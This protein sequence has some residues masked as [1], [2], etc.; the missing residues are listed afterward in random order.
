MK[1]AQKRVFTYYVL[2]EYVCTLD[3][4]CSQKN[5]VPEKNDSEMSEAFSNVSVE[6]LSDYMKAQFH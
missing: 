2:F 3:V 1:C 4:E 6:S 5:G